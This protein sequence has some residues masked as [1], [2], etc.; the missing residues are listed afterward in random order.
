MNPLLKKTLGFIPAV[1]LTLATLGIGAMTALYLYLAPQLPATDTLTEVRLQVPLKVYTREGRLIAE[2]GEMRRIPVQFGQVPRQLVQAV[3]AAEDDRFYSHPGVDYQGLLRAALS[4]AATGEKKQGGSTI[5]MQVAR[6][7]FLSSEKTYLRKFKEIL[8]ALRIEQS[9][10][11]DQ[12]LEL[13]LNKIYCGNRAYGV[14][15]AAQFYYGAELNQL[16][17]AQMATLAGLPKAPSK[18][19]PLANRERAVER[20]D[21]ILERMAA[22][23]YISEAEYQTAHS[24]PET[25]ARHNPEIEVEAPHVAEMARAEMVRRYGETEAYTG[26]Y[27]VYTTLDA[28]Q[29]MAASQALRAALLEY[30][31]RHGYRKPEGH[32]ELK[33]DA[34]GAG[35]QAALEGYS[36]SGGL[37]PALALE[38]EGQNARVYT[39][40]RGVLELSWAGLSWASPY[41]AENRRGPPPKNAA[42]ILQAGDI[43]RIYRDSGGV[44]RLAQLPAVEGALVALHPANGA[45]T[46]LAGGFN[47]YQSNFNRVLQASRQPGSSFKPFLYSAALERGYTPASVV[48]DAPVIVEGADLDDSTWR[49]KNFGGKFYGPTRL[50]E[51]L[52][53]SRNMV[54]IRVLRAIGVPYAVEYAARFGFKPEQLPR[55]PSLALGSGAVT[56]LDLVRAYAVFANGGYLVE[57]YFIDRIVDAQGK[58]LMQADPLTV[59]ARCEGSAPALALAQKGAPRVI[60][61]QNAYLMTSMLQDVIRTGTGRRALELQRADLAGKTGTTNDLRDAW[62]AGFN[63]VLASVA[64]V[65]FDDHAPLGDEE[66]GGRAALPMWMRF[67]EV[68]LKDVPEQPYPAPEGIVTLRIDPASGALAAE[69]DARAI[70][71]LFNS[72]QLPSQITQ[73]VA[74]PQDA[75]GTEQLF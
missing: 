64:W 38:V 32:V 15:A 43:I 63:P 16:T 23:G 11:K 59:C 71:E 4:L 60:S 29:Q 58:V 24:A 3:L 55:V 5:T 74:A 36:E 1:L 53:H 17:L 28:R 42:Q 62:F 51:A 57:P 73:P 50:R 2:F 26:G 65:G 8:L 35:W 54:S 48:N 39:P 9:L 75:I 37:L 49:P 70:S 33:K 14:A 66:T 25:A 56:P 30:D 40:G 22:L 20:R 69:D 6:N 44:W 41:L 68:A 47:F 61:A 10:S 19:N 34:G 72:G 67:M 13:Y 46:A 31:Q 45:I 21:Y 12:I 52:A 27:E 7:F 18:Y